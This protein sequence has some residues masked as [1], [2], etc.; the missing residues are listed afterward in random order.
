MRTGIAVAVLVAHALGIAAYRGAGVAVD[1]VF[2]RAA[3]VVADGG[4]LA[5]HGKLHAVA[6]HAYLVG[7]GDV[8]GAAQSLDAAHAAVAIHGIVDREGGGVEGRLILDL[9]DGAV[10]TLLQRHAL[11]R[12]AGIHGGGTLVLESGAEVIFGGC[13]AK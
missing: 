4:V 6:H 9:D 1:I 12:E 3:A 10:G 7:G 11:G 5:G 13:A 2:D 8:A